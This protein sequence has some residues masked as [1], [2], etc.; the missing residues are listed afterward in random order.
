MHNP[1]KSLF[2]EYARDALLGGMIGIFFGSA[3]C[4]IIA[5]VVGSCA[6]VISGASQETQAAAVFPTLSASALTCVIVGG[7]LGARAGHYEGLGLSFTVIKGVLVG[8]SVGV[9]AT[10]FTSITVCVIVGSVTGILS[11]LWFDR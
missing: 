6:Y 11:G 4:V 5:L 7:I 1:K 2:D 3:S 8:G 10:L 9:I